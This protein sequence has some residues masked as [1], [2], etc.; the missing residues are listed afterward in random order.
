MRYAAVCAVLLIFLGCVSVIGTERF[1]F[2]QEQRLVADQ[3]ISVFENDTPRIQY[4]YAEDLDDGRGITAGRAGFTSATGDMLD[5]IERYT[6]IQPDNPL[7][8]YLPRLEELAATENA[9]TE[10]LDGLIEAWELAAEDEA[11]RKVQ[12]EVVDEEYY[13]PAT[14]H[15]RSWGSHGL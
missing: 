13:G 8:K 5:V 4:G 11:F 7:A 14:V 12:D 9:S 3:I 10:G 1:I 6:E 2:N 15:V